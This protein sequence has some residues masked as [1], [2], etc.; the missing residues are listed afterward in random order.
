MKVFILMLINGLALQCQKDLKDTVIGGIPDHFNRYTFPW[1][2]CSLFHQMP[3]V[4]PALM[5]GSR[6]V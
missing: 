3:V 5:P 6:S 1:H 4:Y 2:C